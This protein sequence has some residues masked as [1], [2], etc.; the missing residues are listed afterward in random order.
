MI[1]PIVGSTFTPT[2]L[3]TITKKHNTIIYPNPATTFISILNTQ[4]ATAYC[5]I[6][7]TGKIIQKNSISNNNISVNQLPI[8]QYYLQLFTATQQL[9]STTPF[10]KQ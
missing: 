6:D 8:G 3:Q 1:R 5:L 10:T 2:A 9:I 4:D 7:N